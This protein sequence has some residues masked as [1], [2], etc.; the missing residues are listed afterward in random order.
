MAVA[1]DLDGSGSPDVS[2]FEF[3][4]NGQDTFSSMYPDFKKS[5]FM[6]YGDF[7]LEDAN[8]TTIFFELRH[9]EK[10]TY[11]IVGGNQ[12][13]PW[14]PATHDKNIFNPDNE[15]GFDAG[16]MGATDSS[17]EFFVEDAIA[18]YNEAYN[19]TVQEFYKANGLVSPY[20]GWFGNYPNGSYFWPFRRINSQGLY[21]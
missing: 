20:G 13:Y 14:V 8:N 17:N 15:I 7:A 9:A 2:K 18:T 11:S 4:R 12:L 10:E 5:T 21:Y 19:E 16:L 3:N 1:V 6:A